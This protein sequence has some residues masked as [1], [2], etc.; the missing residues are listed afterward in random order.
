MSMTSWTG[1]LF[2]SAFETALFV[3]A[4]LLWVFT[5]VVHG[6]ILIIRRRRKGAGMK[7]ARDRFSGLAVRSML[8]LSIIIAF[9]LALKGITIAPD[10]LFY[11]GVVLTVTGV[12]VRQWALFTLGL[13]FTPVIAVQAGQKVVDA[14]PYRLIRHPSYLGIL[15]TAVGIGFML[16]SLAGVAVIV[17]L[18]GPAVGYRI[19]IEERFLASELGDEYTRYM[20]R[21]KRLVPFLL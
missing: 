12:L 8:Y 2:N 16:R 3:M 14:G 1:T 19:W 6:A 4:V 21:T 11:A 15:L 10:W 7:A 17:A 5:D 9:G 13:Y 18:C 20:K